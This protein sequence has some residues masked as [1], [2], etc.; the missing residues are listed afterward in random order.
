MTAAVTAASPIAECS[1][2]TD[3][4]VSIGL[5][6]YNGDR[7]LETSA[8]SLLAQTYRNIE[9]I[10]CDNA[11]ND[12]TEAICRRLAGEDL[13][14]R[15]YRNG[16]NIGGAKNHNLTFEFARGEY[17]RWA[18]HDDIAHPELIERCIAVLEA[19]RGV[20]VC[21]TSFEHIDADG[22]VVGDVTRNHCGSP[23]PSQR[24]AAMA[25]ARDYCEE[26]YGVIRSEVFA[27]TKLQQDYT[28]SDRTLMSEIALYGRF[29]NVAETL[30]Q[31]RLHPGNQYVDWRTRM[32]WFGDQYRGK[33]VL[34]WWKQFADYVRVIGRV[35][36][37]SGER[38]QC[39]IFMVRWLVVHAPKLGKD[40]LAAGAMSV[41]SR[42]DRLRRFAA[43][44]N[45]S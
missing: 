44:E 14:V 31:K 32:A 41:R 13:R 30:F 9:L 6:V 34:P 21:H 15:Y 42:R 3:P 19:D 28:G 4:L 23:L 17:F 5:P 10:I 25:S 18:A 29:H 8:R 37:T 20:V 7:Y 35:P 36:L 16:T 12:D 45:W 2:V 40:V 38:R 33:L 1:Q 11:S 24:F 27:R 26:T 39:R 43:T 22:T